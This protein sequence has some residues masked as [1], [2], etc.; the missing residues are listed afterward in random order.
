MTNTIEASALKAEIHQAAKGERE[1]ALLDIREH[2]QYGGGHPFFAVSCP[3]SVLE[4]RAPVL[5]PRRTAPVVIFDDD[6][7]VAGLAAAALG[8]IGYGDVRVLKGGA[9]GWK[10]WRG[11]GSKVSTAKRRPPACATRPAS[12]MIA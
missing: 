3:Y 10:T 5:V 12:P 2:G 8:R 1:L 11:W 9:P 7:G 4:L 6:D